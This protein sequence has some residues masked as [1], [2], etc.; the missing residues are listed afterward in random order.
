MR[1]KSPFG[2]ML[3]TELNENGDDHKQKISCDPALAF[4]APICY[5][6]G[7]AAP[8]PKADAASKRN[9]E[10]GMT[11]H[12]LTRALLI[13]LALAAVAAVAVAAATRQKSGTPASSAPPESGAVP[14]ETHG[15]FSRISQEEARERMARDDGHAVVDVRRQDEYDG[16]HIPGA[17]CVPNESIGESRPEAL[18]DPDQIL[19]VYC[20]SGRRSKEAAQKLADLGYRN[21]YEFGG[22]LTWT[23]ETEMKRDET[24]PAKPTPVLVIE[25][26]GKRFYAPPE[27]NSS[28][29]ALIDKLSSGPLTVEMSD[30]GNFEKVGALPWELPR[31]DERITTKPGDVILYQ[32]D[33]ITLYYDENTWS[34]TRLA[35]IGS[36]TRED[37]LAALGSG[38]VTVRFSLE[39]S[40]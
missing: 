39:W 32:G 16:G 19:L 21:V 15:I 18:P 33:R 11:K 4:R 25:A 26:N 20:R 9:P 30:Y 7:K 12:N 29:A 36:A 34:F 13:A 28:A 2:K 17:I 37:L 3:E 35:A 24:A 31:N 10:F 14:A 22:I 40:E 38:D 5:N 23:G 1:G 6:D 27:D 8:L